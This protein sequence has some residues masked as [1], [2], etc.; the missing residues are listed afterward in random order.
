[1]DRNPCMLFVHLGLSL[2]VLLGLSARLDQSE[3]PEVL[4]LLTSG[5]CSWWPQHRGLG[6]SG[7][8]MPLTWQRLAMDL[9]QPAHVVGTSHV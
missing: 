3:K 8:T 1:M 4:V 6:G 2:A 5:D 9:L 7:N